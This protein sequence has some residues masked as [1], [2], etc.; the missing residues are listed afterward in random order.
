MGLIA[1]A[2]APA[3]AQSSARAVPVKPVRTLPAPGSAS[4]RIVV[5]FAEGTGVRLGARGFEAPA[6]D[7]ASL[8]DVLDALGIG[9]GAVRPLFDRPA[10]T[11][12]A[13][14]REGERR[15]GRE[16][17]DLGLYYAI[18][19]P[20]GRRV[21][22]V[23]DALNGLAI[24]ELAMPVP[25]PAP[26]PVDLAPPT[27]DLTSGQGYLS[28][29][30]V[31]V[32][33]SDVASVPG[34]DGAG[35][36]I[37]DAE[38]S[39]TLAHED[40]ELPPSASIDGLVGVDPFPDDGNHGTAVLGVLGARRNGYGVGGLAPA[41]SHR[42]APV[43][44]AEL[45]YDVG[46]AVSIATGVLGPGDVILLEQQ[47]GVCGSLCDNAAATGC[48]PVEYYLPWYD[49]IATATAL[50]ITVVEA[51][52]NG[53]VDL[54]GPACGGLFDRQRADSGAI[55][56]GAGSPFDRSRLFFSSYGSRVDV[57]GWGIFVTTTGYGGLFDPDDVRQRYTDSFSGT[58]S[59][60]AI[61]AGVVAAIQ[62]ARIAAGNDPFTPR[63]LRAHLR[64]TGTPQTLG[65]FALTG[66]I[67][68]LPNLARAIQCGNGAL[69]PNESCDD[70]GL[71][72]RDGCSPTCEVE[73]C[74][75]CAGEPS[76]CVP[77]AKACI[78]C[79]RAIVSEGARA[80][81]A[82]A[83]ALAKCESAKIAGALPAAGACAGEPVTVRRIAKASAR[84]AAKIAAAC[85]G[86]DKVC[87]TFDRNEVTAA[88][89]RWPATCPDLDHGGCTN[90]IGDCGDVVTCLECM[91]GA[92]AE[93]TS[94][95]ASGALNPSDP[96]LARRLN[97]CQRAIGEAAAADFVA[98]SRALQQCW[99]GRARQRHEDDCSTLNGVS[100]AA[101]AAALREERL[102]AKLVRKIC[103]A[104]GGP[105]GLC[106][107]VDDLLPDAIGFT[108]FCEAV[109]TP[110][111]RP[112]ARPVA[113]V[114]DLIGCVDCVAEHYAACA[115]AVT[116]PEFM[117][118]P[119]ACNTPPLGPCCETHA[120]AGCEADEC[121]ACVCGRDLFC[122]AVAWDETCAREAELK[123]GIVCRCDQ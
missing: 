58:S 18:V 117:S 15:A 102:Q 21:A 24:V 10:A 116:V 38:F 113:S 17:A 106:D 65:A 68:P 8:A 85:G 29:A 35:I 107:G 50:G 27:P 43:F 41:A 119:D 75:S 95:Q 31:G 36:T 115:D 33:A 5:K 26:P 77:P 70:G 56:V 62:G 12:A 82:R 100:P 32:G 72:A 28:S 54:D 93:R 23:A 49:A 108:P 2:S 9:G 86:A 37:V 114:G 20:P 1:A 40:L 88:T 4:D 96:R 44:T 59:A 74:A 51:A 22:E 66:T 78:K 61:V 80:A 34:A 120:T 30:P 83:T 48:G 73:A 14:R 90:P 63:A 47:I 109:T 91:Q 87:G 110:R 42:V 118:Y 112:C 94:M 84:M 11:L 121:S 46:R 92:A 111:G 71:K 16:L 7:L 45:G 101:R 53:N 67:G 104:C 98:R 123:C 103:K 57:Q 105:D 122:C 6:H 60:S 79:T 81:A 39:W 97:R 55:I 25:L 89:L 52:G 13:E 99:D 69:D 64:A 3:D 76:I 19:L